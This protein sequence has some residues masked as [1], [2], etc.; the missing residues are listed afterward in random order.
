MKTYYVDAN[1]AWQKHSFARQVIKVSSKCL[2]KQC[3]MY[4]W[5]IIWKS[6]SAANYSIYL[7]CSEA[8][9]FFIGHIVTFYDVY[10]FYKQTPRGS[11]LKYC[12]PVFQSFYNRQC[13]IIMYRNLQKR[14]MRRI[15]M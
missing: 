9:S 5:N 10:S 15:D 7:V 14:V 13:M 8:A 12:N 4:T 3:F 1:T 2:F 6:D 11:Y